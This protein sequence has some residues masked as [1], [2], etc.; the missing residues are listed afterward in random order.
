MK[1][2]AAAGDG[3]DVQ[4]RIKESIAQ[5]F[6]DG[7]D[8]SNYFCE[9]LFFSVFCGCSRV[10]NLQAPR[11]RLW[12]VSKAFKLHI[13]HRTI[14]A[15]LNLKFYPLQRGLCVEIRACAMD[16]MQDFPAGR[17]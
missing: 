6:D 3:D 1:M 14:W 17:R 15:H 13:N 2:A 9:S 16:P 4:V 10:Q 5:D 11:G 7:N 12:T 8:S